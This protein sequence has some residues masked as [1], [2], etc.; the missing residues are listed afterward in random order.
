MG[1]G[2]RQRGTRHQTGQAVSISLSEAAFAALLSDEP[3]VQL[4]PLRKKWDLSRGS[5]IDPQST[6]RS[7]GQHKP[8]PVL[9]QL[10]VQIS[11]K[12]QVPPCV[13]HAIAIANSDAERDTVLTS[14][15]NQS[16]DVSVKLQ[17]AIH[18]SHAF[19]NAF[20]KSMA[21]E[22]RIEA[23]ARMHA[24]GSIPDPME[25]EDTYAAQIRSGTLPIHVARNLPHRLGNLGTL[26]PMSIDGTLAHPVQ[27]SAAQ[28]WV[29]LCRDPY[30]LEEAVDIAREIA[31]PQF[32]DAH[33]SQIGT[34]PQ[35]AG[36]S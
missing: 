20:L 32:P 2:I 6:Q 19:A 30:K 15:F 34:A 31:H 12:T 26:V 36:A 4:E 10:G 9:L 14:L 16:T 22:P 28:R 33:A 13:E 3:Q 5:T 8:T 24:A 29:T 35:P 21:M 11:A 1:W 23:W 17:C 27:H 18:M 7:N 25:R